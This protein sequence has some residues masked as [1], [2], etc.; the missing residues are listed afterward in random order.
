MDKESALLREENEQRILHEV[1]LR[2]ELEVED[3]CPQTKQ[4]K[5]KRYNDIVVEILTYPFCSDWRTSRKR[6]AKFKKYLYHDPATVFKAVSNSFQEHVNIGDKVTLDETMWLVFQLCTLKENPILTVGKYSELAYSKCPYCL[7]FIPD[8]EWKK[9]D[10]H[11]A[12][13]Q[14]KPL[15]TKDQ[16]ALT[17]DNW[18]GMM[19]WVKFNHLLFLCLNL[20]MNTYG[21]FLP[22]ILSQKKE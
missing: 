20:N 7:Y 15:L 6:L 16:P 4:K 2:V 12:L 10:N 17:A 1:S 19:N 8:I 13:N 14:F 11:A 22:T 3:S 18:F 5:Y 9:F 21:M